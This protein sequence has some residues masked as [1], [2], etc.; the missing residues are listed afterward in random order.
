MMNENQNDGPK[1]DIRIEHGKTDDDILSAQ[2][3]VKGHASDVMNVPEF[4]KVHTALAKAKEL[5]IV[6]EKVLNSEGERE[7][8]LLSIPYLNTSSN[9]DRE[10]T[11]GALARIVQTAYCLQEHRVES[12]HF[13]DGGEGQIKGKLIFGSIKFP[14]GRELPFGEQECRNRLLHNTD[15][16]T[17]LILNAYDQRFKDWIFSPSY[18][19]NNYYGMYDE[20]LSQRIIDYMQKHERS[21]THFLHE[22][23]YLREMS[24]A[25][26]TVTWNVTQIWTAEGKPG[27]Q[28][29]NGKTYHADA[30]MAFC[31]AF[32]TALHEKDAVRAAQKAQILNAIR[33]SSPAHIPIVQLTN[34]L[35]QHIQD[36]CIKAN[37]KVRILSPVV[38]FPVPPVRLKLV[39]ELGGGY[40]IDRAYKIR[41]AAT[42]VPLLPPNIGP[43]ELFTKNTT[44]APF[45]PDIPNPAAAGSSHDKTQVQ[46]PEMKLLERRA[47]LEQCL[48]E[49]RIPAS[50][51]T[52]DLAPTQRSRYDADTNQRMQYVKIDVPAKGIRFLVSDDAWKRTYCEYIRGPQEVHETD[53]S[54]LSRQQLR[55]QKG[56]IE[57]NYES[58]T[59]FKRAIELILTANKTVHPADRDAFPESPWNQEPFPSQQCIALLREDLWKVAVTVHERARLN[60]SAAHAK[61]PWELSV[62]DFKSIHSADVLFRFNG[63]VSGSTWLDNLTQTLNERKDG[64]PIV[65]R[66][67]TQNL[68]SLP[69]GQ[70]RRTQRNILGG[71]EIIGYRQLTLRILKRMA[72]G[73]EVERRIGM[74]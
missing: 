28:F 29:H 20:E 72:F 8:V 49:H 66:S 32:M 57:I 33:T 44:N 35:L 45:L 50:F 16:L 46:V 4:K 9:I 27:L 19:T 30:L 7:V 31:D 6:T 47:V 25:Q 40:P 61:A 3:A 5:G 58:P 64:K 15:D 22:F 23:A 11:A 26:G 41:E 13:I 21:I 67:S 10:R 53:Y 54:L 51:T 71:E 2:A 36:A 55:K 12:P 73:E 74:E 14:D 52:V 70:Q 37:Y 60:N 42:N 43:E 56:A 24:N 62:I 69:E 59:Q 18:A 48:V 1:P 38:D 68:D 17:K 63:P 39:S 34:D 65:Q